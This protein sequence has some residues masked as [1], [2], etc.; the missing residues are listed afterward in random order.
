M[1]QRAVDRAGDLCYIYYICYIVEERWS[2]WRA[3]KSG[4]IVLEIDPAL[5]R[6][7]YLKLGQDDVTLKEWFLRTAERYIRG[8][9]PLEQSSPT[10]RSRLTRMGIDFLGNKERFCPFSTR[11]SARRPPDFRGRWGWWTCFA[12]RGRSADASSPTAVG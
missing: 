6:Q 12:G 4:R 2:P 1:C 7:L 5:K 9:D 11:I 8:R 3:G 10:K